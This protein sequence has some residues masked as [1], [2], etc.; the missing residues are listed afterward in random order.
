M[1]PM[2][3]L[4][5]AALLAL[6]LRLAAQEPAPAPTPPPPP[7]PAAEPAPAV[8][9]PGMSEAEVRAIWGDPAV[10]KHNND[11]TFLFYRNYEEHR[12][13]WLDVVFL[14]NGQV[15]DCIAR[16]S[17]HAYAGQSSS[18]PDRV[19]GPTR[20]ATPDESTSGA[21]TGVRVNP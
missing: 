10:V 12:V 17:G 4:T 7:P 2:L 15:V 9:R 8:L 19:P 20:S 14:Q 3:A 13:G 11:W 21:V 5:A 1:R 18:P 16:G 6:P